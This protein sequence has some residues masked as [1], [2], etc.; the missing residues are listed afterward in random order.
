ME[1]GID[2]LD[3]KMKEKYMK[4]QIQKANCQEWMDAFFG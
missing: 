2:D 1:L 3:Y 4:I